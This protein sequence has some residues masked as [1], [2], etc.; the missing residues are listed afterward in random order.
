MKTSLILIACAALNVSA[1][2]IA[3]SAE[4]SPDNRTVTRVRVTESKSRLS[5]VAV[6]GWT[7]RSDATARRLY[8]Q[9]AGEPRGTIRV[10]MNNDGSF[11]NAN[12]LRRRLTSE[13]QSA[14]IVDEFHAS[15]SGLIGVGMDVR[16][17]A[18]GKVDMMC[19][20]FL[21]KTLDGVAEVRL[22]ATAK[23][24]AALQDRWTAFINSFRVEKVLIAARQSDETLQ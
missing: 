14:T 22:S 20:V 5:F 10:Q 16:Y 15:S 11:V 2:E 18:N 12:Q 24:W 13:L 8:M 23:D 7:S 17:S 4:E 19:R 6:D 3:K 1:F 21:F 9:A